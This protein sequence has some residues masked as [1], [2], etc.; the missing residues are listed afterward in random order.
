MKKIIK[1]ALCLFNDPQKEI[2]NDKRF[3]DLMYQM[4]KIQ[5]IDNKVWA[6]V[7]LLKKI[8]VIRDNGGFSKLIISLK[9]RNH[10]QLNEIIKSLE[11]I[12]EHIERAGRNRKGINRTNRGEEVTTDKVF[13][14]KIFGLPIQTASYWLERQ[15]IM[16]KEIRED[17]KDDFV[18]TV[19][20]WTCINNQAGNF[21]TCHAGGILK[22]LE[23]I[24][25]FSEKNNN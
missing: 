19:T 11:T 22:E 18:K 10:G 25:I 8:A 20:N 2:K 9:K 5:E 3:G 4:L 16:K 15:E 12:Q 7:A 17:L 24:K 1:M 23:K 13:F 6:M 21:V 14:G